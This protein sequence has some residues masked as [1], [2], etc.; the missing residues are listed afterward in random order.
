MSRILL[1]PLALLWGCT[2]EGEPDPRPTR[3]SE[4]FKIVEYLPSPGQTGVSRSSHIDLIFNAP[5]DATHVST[6][7]LRLFSGL[8]ERLGAVKVDLL[9]RR[10]RFS[11]TSSL[12]AELRYRFFISARLRGLNGVELADNVFFDFTT[13]TGSQAPPADKL[14]VVTARDVQPIWAD[15]CISCHGATAPPARVDLSSSTAAVSSLMGVPSAHGDRPRVVPGDHAG[16]YLMLKLLDGG[17]ITGF[18][19][20]PSGPALTARQLRLVAD[21]IDGGALP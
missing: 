9:R 20:P 6:T 12:R 7:Y 13:G 19:M 18:P 4:T 21:W 10:I 8:Y 1:V 17:R 15:R 16:S 14:P 2:Y 11:P 3:T 5:P